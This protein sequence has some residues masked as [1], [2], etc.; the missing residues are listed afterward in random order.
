MSI[1]HHDKLRNECQKHFLPVR[2]ADFTRI[3]D[4][5]GVLGVSSKKRPPFSVNINQS[6]NK[7]QTGLYP[8][9]RAESCLCLMKAEKVIFLRETA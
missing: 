8:C 4:V 7:K 6:E 9:E 3:V 1:G 5:Q 2:T